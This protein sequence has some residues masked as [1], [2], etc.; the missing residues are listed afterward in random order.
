MTQGSSVMTSFLT[1]IWRIWCRCIC[2]QKCSRHCLPHH[3]CHHHQH[4]ESSS[5]SVEA[6]LN[7]WL[8]ELLRTPSL[9]IGTPQ[10]I[11]VMSHI[12]IRNHYHKY[13][14]HHCHPHSHSSSWLLTLPI[15]V[16]CIVMSHIRN[17][18]HHCHT[19]SWYSSDFFFYPTSFAILRLT[20]ILKT[21][22]SFRSNRSLI[23]GVSL[24]SSSSSLLSLTIMTAPSAHLSQLHCCN[25]KRHRRRNQGG[26][27][28]DWGD[29]RMMTSNRMIIWWVQAI[30]W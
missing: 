9:D 5:S 21:N 13:H 4:L 18:F 24:T 6:I 28:M 14:F 19:S 8:T 29:K 3:H 22:Q 7:L 30:G 25:L 20:F 16:N 23:S 12:H 15:R 27:P 11:I 2:H 26:R 10:V 1:L 17:H